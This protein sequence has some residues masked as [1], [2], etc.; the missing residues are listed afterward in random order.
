MKDDQR[1]PV[2]A[3]H[4]N[5]QSL[6]PSMDNLLTWMEGEMTARMRSGA[7]IHKSGTLSHS[8]VNRFSSRNDNQVGKRG[9]SSSNANN[10]MSAC[11][12]K[13]YVDECQRFQGMSPSERWR[14]VKEHAKSM[15][16]VFEEK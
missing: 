12:G 1:G 7:T 13:H 6:D 9:T 8:N 4:I 5:S 2:W 3:R 15:F 14:I 16:F 11:Q 10:V